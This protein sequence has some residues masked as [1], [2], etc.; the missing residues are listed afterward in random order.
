MARINLRK[1]RVTARVI[2]YGPGR[3]GKTTNLVYVRDNLNSGA[4][5][6]LSS[7]A[8]R[9]EVPQYIDVL[10]VKFGEILGFETTFHLCAAGGQA[11][12]NDARKL[13]LKASDG[14]VFVADSQVRRM[15]ANLDSLLNLRENL[16]AFGMK[17][18]NIPH[19][20][21]YNKRDLEGIVS[22]A[23]LRRDLNLLGVPDFQASAVQG[24]GVLA[25]LESVIDAVTRDLVSRI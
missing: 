14:I 1:K 12:Q 15:D 24:R 17:L 18:E 6:Q 11:F 4:A 10:P 20:I 5:G 16:A 3:S 9:T 2:Y 7:V 21:Q 19:V 13:L 8:A 23:E 22:V 25:T